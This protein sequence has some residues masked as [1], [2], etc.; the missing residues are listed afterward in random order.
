ME[1]AW[2][3]L[4]GAVVPQPLVSLALHGRLVLRTAAVDRLFEYLGIR[5]EQSEDAEAIDLAQPTDRPER[6][7]GA[8][9]R[10]ATSLS[11]GSD[12]ADRRLSSLLQAIGEFAAEATPSDRDLSG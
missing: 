1:I 12:A 9:M 10:L 6:R 5:P 8:I 7:I 2:E 11:D 3:S 4:E